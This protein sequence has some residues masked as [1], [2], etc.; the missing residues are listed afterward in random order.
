MRK[1]YWSPVKEIERIECTTQQN[2]TGNASFKP[3]VLIQLFMAE[4]LNKGCKK[5]RMQPDK[6]WILVF[7]RWADLNGSGRSSVAT[8]KRVVLIIL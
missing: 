7:G 5:S 4:N 2:V 3:F 8:A 6:T 1:N